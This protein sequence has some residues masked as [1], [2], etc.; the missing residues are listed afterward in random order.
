[1]G[2]D[3][4]VNSIIA[5][6]PV[7]AI[8]TGKTAS[9]AQAQEAHKFIRGL[10]VELFDEPVARGVRIQYGG[11]VNPSNTRELT[12]LPDVDGALVGRASKP[13]VLRAQSKILFNQKPEREAERVLA[14]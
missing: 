14:I 9:P 3:Q 13:G 10:L 2:K 8:G 5:Y 11:S 6:E 4:I 7:W 1:M 12:S